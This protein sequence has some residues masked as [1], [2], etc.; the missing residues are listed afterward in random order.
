M[1]LNVFFVVILSVKWRV[2][3]FLRDEDTFISLKRHF[4]RE[5]KGYNFETF[6]KILEK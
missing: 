3:S 4:L 5:F 1:G 6:T 2:G